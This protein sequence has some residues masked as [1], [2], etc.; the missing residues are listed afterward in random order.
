MIAK[1][2]QALLTSILQHLVCWQKPWQEEGHRQGVDMSE[3]VE[4]DLEPRMLW[5]ALIAWRDAFESLAIT[6]LE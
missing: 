4:S 1:E 2:V 5:P 6:T 3:E